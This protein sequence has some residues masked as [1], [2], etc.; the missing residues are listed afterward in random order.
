LKGLVL[1]S[2]PLRC[3]GVMAA[4]LD[5]DVLLHLLFKFIGEV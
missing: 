4:V 5:V 2:A 1:E 3:C